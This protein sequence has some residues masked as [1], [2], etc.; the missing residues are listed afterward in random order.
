[1]HI[2]QRRA[3]YHDNIIKQCVL[4]VKRYFASFSIKESA[5]D[6]YRAFDE[7]CSRYPYYESRFVG[8]TN[9]SYGLKEIMPIEVIGDGVKM[10]YSG[11]EVKIPVEYDYYLTSIFG[12]YHEDLDEEFVRNAMQ[13]TCRVKNKTYKKIVSLCEK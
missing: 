2:K 6:L 7:L 10:N 5:A 12:N 11:F 4:R 1:F 9:N 13:Y 8:K 3:V